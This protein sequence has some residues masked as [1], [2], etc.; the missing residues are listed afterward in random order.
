MCRRIAIS[1]AQYLAV[2]VDKKLRK[3]LAGNADTDDAVCLTSG[4]RRITIAIIC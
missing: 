4:F 1:D 3:Y 2:Q